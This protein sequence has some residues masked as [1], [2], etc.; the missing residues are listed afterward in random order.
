[1]IIEADEVEVYVLDSVL[2]KQVLGLDELA[3]IQVVQHAG[4][5][6][7][8]ELSVVQGRLVTIDAL[9]AHAMEELVSMVAHV[10]AFLVGRS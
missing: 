6:Q 5:G 7:S 4:L 9:H 3:E 1:M 10:Q 8:E 2:V